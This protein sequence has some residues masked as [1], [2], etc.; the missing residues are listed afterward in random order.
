MAQLSVV[1]NVGTAF[2][3]KIHMYKVNVFFLAHMFPQIRIGV[4]SI[5]GIC[6]FKKKGEKSLILRLNKIFSS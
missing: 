6:R 2:G 1:L 3:L 5:F 4:L